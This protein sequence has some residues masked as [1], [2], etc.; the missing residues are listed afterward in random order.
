MRNDKMRTNTILVL[1]WRLTTIPFPSFSLSLGSK[2]SAF[3][4]SILIFRAHTHAHTHTHILRNVK[5]VVHLQCLISH[6]QWRQKSRIIQ[7]FSSFIQ[8][9]IFPFIYTMEPIQFFFPSP[10]FLT[11]QKSTR[12]QKK[13]CRI[14]EDQKIRNT[15]IQR[16][17]K[18]SEM[19]VCEKN[20]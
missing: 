8:M 11:F 15:Q 4:R 20:V 7:V 10:P 18:T 2:F 14:N 16:R 9:G 19:E 5:M 1:C 3:E 17:M 12:A 13:T 6:W